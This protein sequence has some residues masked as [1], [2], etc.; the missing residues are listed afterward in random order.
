VGSV[1]AY[2]I[3]L[4]SAAG[5][6]VENNWVGNRAWPRGRSLVEQGTL[7]RYGFT[8]REHS[9]TGGTGLY[10]YRAR[11]YDPK[12]GR[13]LSEDPIRF[14]GGINF[15]SY[16]FDNPVNMTD[17][18]GLDAYSCKIPA[19][20]EPRDKSD[21]ATGPDYLPF[22]IPNPLSHQYICV[23]HPDGTKTCGGTRPAVKDPPF[24]SWVPSEPSQDSFEPAR[25][26]QIS[27]NP[28]SC[29]ENCLERK[30]HPGAGRPPYR[31]FPTGSCQTFVGKGI[32]DCWLQCGGR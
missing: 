21:R 14:E 6:V 19:V 2:G 25:C 5:A 11:Y 27:S 26:D 29:F 13:F 3:Q 10:Y 1:T 30:I 8:G 23:V 17:A 12:I 16:V 32:L 20:G 15:Y 4:S 22:G 28:G 7:S 24:F 31:V 9:G 18:F